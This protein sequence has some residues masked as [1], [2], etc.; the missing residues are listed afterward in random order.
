MIELTVVVDAFNGKI[1]DDLTIKAKKGD[2]LIVSKEAW[3][4]IQA[5]YGKWFKFVQEIKE[6][7]EV[8]E[9]VEV[10]YN[11]MMPSRYKNK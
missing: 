2:K 8:K 6:V 10:P 1:T 3:N 11:K 4:V 5:K 7:S 9:V